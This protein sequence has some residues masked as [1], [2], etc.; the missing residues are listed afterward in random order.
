MDF[1]KK[2][3]YKLTC[4]AKWEGDT[5]FNFPYCYYDYAG[6]AIMDSNNVTNNYLSLNVKHGECFMLETKN[7]FGRD[8]N[9]LTFN[10]VKHMVHISYEF[11]KANSSI[12][13]DVTKQFERDN[14][15]K[16]ILQ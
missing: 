7:V 4:H 8:R 12:F 6:A 2:K 9:I 1:E 10:N 11:L 16:E 13:V 15:I 14:I 5:S 3:Y